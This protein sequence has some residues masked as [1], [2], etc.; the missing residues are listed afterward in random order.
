[1]M[2]RNGIRVLATSRLIINLKRSLF[3]SAAISAPSL[4]ELNVSILNDKAYNI[5]I[6]GDGDL[7]Y[8]LALC[9]HTKNRT[10]R[11]IPSGSL[12]Q[13]FRVTATTYQHGELLNNM[14]PNATVNI[15]ELEKLSAHVRTGV[16][17]TRL[18]ELF[19]PKYFHRIVWNFPQHPGLY[20][21]G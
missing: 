5:L 16:D 20:I 1:M 2:F 14:H 17:A 21:C 4:L 10:Q 11:D 6:C 3:L 12:L 15:A 18:H 7:S 13:N 8:S 19:E 9:R